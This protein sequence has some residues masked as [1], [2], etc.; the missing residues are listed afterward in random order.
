MIIKDHLT[1]NVNDTKYV[2]SM[3]FAKG[4]VPQELNF[5]VLGSDRVRV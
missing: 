4:Y 5:I 3:N 2:V 1:T